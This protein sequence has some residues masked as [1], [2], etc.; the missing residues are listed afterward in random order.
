MDNPSD[1]KKRWSSLEQAA[2]YG[3][4]VGMIPAAIHLFSVWTN[5]AP[6]GQWS[7]REVSPL[8]DVF[9]WTGVLSTGPILFVV[10]ASIRN[11]FFKNSS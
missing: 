4:L 8:D 2:F 5:R 9:Y 11:A 3:F 7:I 10:I 1:V 6:A